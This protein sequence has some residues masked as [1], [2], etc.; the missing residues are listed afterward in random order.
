VLLL[1]NAAISTSGDAEQ[2]VEIGGKR[3][4]HIVDPRTG[5]GLTE[6]WQVSVISTYA[7]QT[8]AAATA[9]NVFGRQR[10]LSFIESQPHLAVLWVQNQGGVVTVYDSDKFGA[11]ARD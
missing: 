10:G 8:D 7:T 3:Y 11:Y 9:L 5:M 6:R 2:F 4:S 1:K